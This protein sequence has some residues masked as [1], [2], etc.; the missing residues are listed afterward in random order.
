MQEDYAVPSSEEE[1]EPEEAAEAAVA[2]EK[3][4]K[5]QVSRSAHPAPSRQML[6][7][8]RASPAELHSASLIP[9][10]SCCPVYPLSCSVAAAPG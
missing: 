2:E 3:P 7:S 9:A 10:C 6:Q 1:S 5:K 4:G 8:V